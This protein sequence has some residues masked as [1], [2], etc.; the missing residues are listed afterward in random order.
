MKEKIISYLKEKYNPLAI[1]LHGSRATNNAGEK[2]DWDIYIFVLELSDIDKFVG[3]DFEGQQLDASLIR[4][5]LDSELRD[6]FIR[7]SP[8]IQIVFDTDSVAKSLYEDLK[9]EHEKGLHF[10]EQMLLQKKTFLLRALNRLEDNVSNEASFFLRLGRDF[11]PRAVNWWFEILNNEYSVPLYK[12][13]PIIKEKDPSYYEHLAV[14]YK[15]G[16][17]EEKL[18]SAKLIFN[19]L[20][21]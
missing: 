13:L 9:I 4:I 19:R 7:T 15:Q 16:K 6:E 12:A 5:P 21:H 11:F 20:F 14:L 1:V 10:S 8:S 2:S 18:E 17:N 3:E